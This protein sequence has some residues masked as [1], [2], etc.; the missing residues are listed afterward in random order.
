MFDDLLEDFKRSLREFDR[1]SSQG[2]LENWRM[3]RKEESTARTMRRFTNAKLAQFEARKEIIFGY[4]SLKDF[5]V[6]GVEAFAEMDLRQRRSIRDY[7]TQLQEL[8]EPV[9]PTAAL[10]PPTPVRRA[11]LQPSRAP[12]VIDGMLNGMARTFPLRGTPRE[13]HQFM[14][15]C[16]QKLSDQGYDQDACEELVSALFDKM[17]GYK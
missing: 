7:R 15:S 14:R 5:E 8:E 4:V 1:I 11:A 3:L 10:P 13:Q 12:E 9:Q 6:K 17:E 2:P 16:A